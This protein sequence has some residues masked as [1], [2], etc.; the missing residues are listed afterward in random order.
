MAC[1][2]CPKRNFLRRKTQQTI[3]TTGAS[4]AAERTTLRSRDRRCPSFQPR[5]T[6]RQ[7]RLG[8]GQARTQDG[9]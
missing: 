7:C 3:A 9:D 6:L 4:E 2:T 1:T 8:M 5:T